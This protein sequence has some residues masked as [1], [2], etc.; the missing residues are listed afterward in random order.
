MAR[1][2]QAQFLTGKSHQQD[3][4][5]ERLLIAADEPGEFENT[6]S[7]GSI[8]VGTVMDLA[9]V[10][11]RKRAVAIPKPEVIIVAADDNPLV[12]ECAVGPADRRDDI[13]N[14]LADCLDICR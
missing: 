9:K 13:S 14:G 1:T 3:G 10:C 11:L 8:V 7:S 12:A 5:C 6:C 2:E 4:P